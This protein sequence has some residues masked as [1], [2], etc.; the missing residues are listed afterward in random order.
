MRSGTIRRYGLVGVGAALLEEMCQYGGGLSGLP[1][2]SSTKC[3]ITGIFWYLQNT[4]SFLLP[5]FGSRC[6][7]Q[8]LLQHHV[9][10]Q[11]AMLPTMMIME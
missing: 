7:T 4:V 2:S 6:G 1:Y 3:E 9:S 8:F 5:D 10:L 11:A